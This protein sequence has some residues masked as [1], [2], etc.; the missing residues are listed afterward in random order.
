MIIAR[1]ILF[2]FVLVVI[3]AFVA[4]RVGQWQTGRGDHAPL[5]LMPGGSAVSPPGRI[6][7][8]TDAACGAANR[9]A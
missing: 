9:S 5:A 4:E 7:I 6:W 3:V 8:D 1:R 2:A